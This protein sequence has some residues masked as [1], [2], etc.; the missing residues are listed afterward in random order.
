MG[1]GGQCPS[2]TG[3]MQS[4][5]MLSG[6][7]SAPRPADDG[8]ASNLRDREGWAGG[9]GGGREGKRERERERENFGIILHI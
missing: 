5:S 6:A 1:V 3:A 7:T 9:G 8:S 2:L 4:A